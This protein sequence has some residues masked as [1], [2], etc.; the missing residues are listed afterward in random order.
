MNK[1]IKPFN[2]YAK[3]TGAHDACRK[4]RGKR[5]KGERNDDTT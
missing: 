2:D 3:M 5:K 1:N 4:G